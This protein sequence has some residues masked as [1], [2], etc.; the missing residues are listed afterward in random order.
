MKRA[1]ICL[2]LLTLAAPAGATNIVLN[3]S[4]E[5]FA[6]PFGDF[7]FWT[8]PGWGTMANSHSGQFAAGTGC[9]ASNTACSI[10]QTLATTA[11]QSYDLSFWVT[12][13]GGPDSGLRIEWDGVEVASLVN[14]AN[15]TCLEG[16][17]FWTQFAFLNLVASTD[18]TLLTIF[19]YQDPATIMLDDVVVEAS[20]DVSAAPVPEPASVALLGLGLIG[21]AARLRKKA[22]GSI[23]AC[24]L[25]LLLPASSASATS[26]VL[27]GGF[28]DGADHWS[29]EDFNLDGFGSFGAHSGSMAASTGC[30]MPAALTTCFVG[31]MLTT[32][33]GATYELGFWVAETAGPT[34]GVAVYWDGLLAAQFTNPANSTCAT[35]DQWCTWVYFSISGLTASTSSTLLQLF[36][37]QDPGFLGF[38]DITVEQTADPMASPVP[39]PASLGLLGSGLIAVVAGYR[40]RLSISRS[41]MASAGV[42]PNTAP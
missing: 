41:S 19:G 35:F 25:A 21:L 40:R 7:A 10:A 37:R 27:N 36:G 5:E 4:F 34:S 2:F 13:S 14:P 30:I 15:N 32:A 8:T 23:S 26:I 6:P 20:A 16:P 11:G 9:L 42:K 39:E 1:A 3:P 17:C 33:P 18:S 28:E 22:A 24:A 12:E 29:S 31:Q 38:D